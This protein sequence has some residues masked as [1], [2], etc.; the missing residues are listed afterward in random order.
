MGMAALIDANVLAC[1]GCG[2]LRNKLLLRGV[3]RF[4]SCIVAG[5][6]GDGVYTILCGGNAVRHFHHGGII[7]G[8]GRFQSECLLAHIAEAVILVERGSG[9]GGVPAGVLILFDELALGIELG[10]GLD[11]A[12]G[13]CLSLHGGLTEAVGN[14]LGNGGTICQL[15]SA[16][17]GIAAEVIHIHHGALC[18]TADGSSGTIRMACGNVGGPCGRGGSGG[19]TICTVSGGSHTAKDVRLFNG[20]AQGIVLRGFSSLHGADAAGGAEGA[21]G[22]IASV[23]RDALR[24]DASLAFVYGGARNLRKLAGRVVGIGGGDAIFIR[25]TQSATAHPF[26]GAEA[27]IAACGLDDALLLI[28]LVSGGVQEQPLRAVP[29]ALLLKGGGII[30]SDEALAL[31]TLRGYQLAVGLGDGGMLVNSTML[32]GGGVFMDCLH[33]GD[34]LTELGL[35]GGVSVGGFSAVCFLDAHLLLIAATGCHDG[36]DALQD[37]LDMLESE[38][39]KFDNG[40]WVW[41]QIGDRDN[42]YL[43]CEAMQVCGA[44]MLKLVGGELI[45]LTK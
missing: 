10:A 25:F 12:T 13:A 2:K 18:R 26:R 42:H 30:R 20:T 8:G 5:M 45:N 15:G 24:R 19:E 32:C 43:D 36:G 6:R 33:P 41:K 29:D 44:I 37:Y 40:H 27:A 39:R 34:I 17:Q 35:T 23:L 38:C 11:E 28:V 7:L 14:I 22:G 21:T 16:A 3:Q 31:A 9:L 4:T 1:Q